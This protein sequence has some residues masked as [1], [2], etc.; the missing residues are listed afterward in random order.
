MC[1]LAVEKMVDV[2]EVK[3][4]KNQFDQNFSEWKKQFIKNFKES[5]PENYKWH[6]E[7]QDWDGVMDELDNIY[8]ESRK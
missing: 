1:L 6:L 7:M 4:Y 3:I 5:Y 8:I 2:E